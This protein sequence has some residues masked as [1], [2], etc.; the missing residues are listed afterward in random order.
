MKRDSRRIRLELEQK[1]RMRI[2]S[3]LLKK[4]NR[5]LQGGKKWKMVMLGINCG[6]K[7]DQIRNGI[8]GKEEGNF[9]FALK[10]E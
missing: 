10:E 9:M 7:R 5:E 8:E 3:C 6:M 1:E 2:I 4:R